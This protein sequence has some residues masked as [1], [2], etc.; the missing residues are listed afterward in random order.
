MATMAS[1]FI[2]TPIQSTPLPKTPRLNFS[3]VTPKSI[4]YT[5]NPTRKPIRISCALIEPDGG[6]LV[7]LVV[8]ESER[9]VKKKEAM[10]LPQIKLSRI[11]LEWVHVL[12]EGW[13]SPIT[14][15]MRESEF[16][17]TL[18]F[19][20][21]RLGDGSVVN[22][23]LPI[24]LDIDD[25][26]KNRISGSTA[27]ALVDSAGN[28]VAIL[29]NIEIYKH[30]KEERIARTWGTTAPG[31]P[32]VEE[33][34]TSAG[35]W[36]IGGD[37]EVIEPIKYHDGLDHYRLSPSALRAEFE[38]RNADAVFAFQLR[39][40]VHNGHALL[41]TDTRRRLLEMGY[42]NPVL[43]L[44]PL[45]GFTKAD[46]VPLSWRMKQHQKVLEDGVLDPENTVVSIFPSPMHYA[47]PTEVQW[48]AKA[49]INA[50][51]NFYIVG[52]DPAGM[53]HPVEKRDLYDADHGKKV[54]SMA[55][56]LERL[57]ILPF[58]VAAYDKTQQKM[59]F[60]DP[61]RSQDFLFISGTKMRTLAKNRENPPDGF[62]CPG[63]WEVLVEYYDSLATNDSGRVPV[64]IP[65]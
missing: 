31:L 2:K 52:R 51:A 1:L 33:A 26:Q 6:Q 65:A 57:N 15:F 11:D 21:L 25:S 5:Q 44:H 58:K 10:G 36:L 9:D 38:K 50:G 43:L 22:M 13:A 27:V 45:G 61:S 39:N 35:D 24:V 7:E 41:M 37:L 32:Y 29:N 56:G 55:P 3:N 16:L 60:F 23:S 34:I 8:P 64:P 62:M 46:D 48:H 47:G 14:G 17:Q 19:N 49:R 4:S 18:H 30:N 63:G 42:K 40:P 54:L 53:S 59:E 20:S 12:S 28:P